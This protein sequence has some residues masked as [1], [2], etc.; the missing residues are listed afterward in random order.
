MFQGLGVAILKIQV[1]V[2]EALLVSFNVK[3]D[4]AFPFL[5]LV[6]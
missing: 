3:A 5:G 6:K 4:S 2:V 1:T